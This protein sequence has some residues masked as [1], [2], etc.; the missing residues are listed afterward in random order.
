MSKY[1]FI[2]LSCVLL[3]AGCRHVQYVAVPSVRTEYHNSIMHDSVDR[4][5]THYEFLRGD[6]LHL[7]D[8][9]YRDR[10][11]TLFVTDSIHDTVPVI[12]T[13]ALHALR[14]DLLR[15]QSLAHSRLLWLVGLIILLAFLLFRRLSQ[16]L[17][18]WLSNP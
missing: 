16:A 3:C 18:R 1:F 5:H 17:D 12:D 13:A 6:T 4:W 7:I 14:A 9:F 8:T 10:L 15:Q 11:V 2:I